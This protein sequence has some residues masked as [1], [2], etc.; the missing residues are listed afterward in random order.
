[1]RSR[2][3]RPGVER[4]LCLALL[5]LLAGCAAGPQR[6]A[7]LAVV[8]RFEPVRPSPQLVRPY[9]A[10]LYGV[11]LCRHGRHLDEVARYIDWYLDHLN[12]GERDGRAGTIDDYVVHHGNRERTTG[13]YD[14]ADGYAGTFLILLDA[15]EQ[16]SGDAGRLLARLDEIQIVAELLLSLQ[17]EDGLVR[18]S[19]TDGTHYLM[20]NCEAYGG[21]VS[22][23]ALERRLGRDAGPR[24]LAAAERLR[25]AIMARL[26]EPA[27]HRFHWAESDAA[28]HASSWDTYYPDALAQLFPVLYG[29]VPA[30]EELAG[31]LWREFA[32]RYDP[33]SGDVRSPSE[34]NIIELTRERVTQ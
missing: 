20:D 10:N 32:A 17:D 27:T 26:Y 14:S 11:S 31:S 6:H 33:R 15:Y 5:V 29:V 25:R 18:V 21:L 19:P 12:E 8:A 23:A 7:A 4:A 28:V 22:W 30:G 24:C 2:S 1:M 13:Q 3:R 34:R 9:F 16:A